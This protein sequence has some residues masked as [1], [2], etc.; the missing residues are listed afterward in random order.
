MRDKLVVSLLLFF[1]IG[2][3]AAPAGAI[4]YGNGFVLRAG[5]GINPDQFVVGAQTILGHI[6]RSPFPRFA[7]SAD[8]GFG[9]EVTMTTINPDFRLMAP[10]PRSNAFMY[11]QAGPTIAIA[12]PKYGD[13]DTKIGLTLSGGLNIPMGEG[14][15]YSLEGRVG[16]GD[17]PD[18]RILL[19]LQFGGR[20]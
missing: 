4:S 11:I 12:D 13:G 9:D 19:G 8:I 2:A 7:P 20:R 10:L 16:I 5:A 6:F 18:V 1:A 17:V 15:Y 3:L 14:S